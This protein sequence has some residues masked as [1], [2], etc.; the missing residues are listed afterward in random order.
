MICFIKRRKALA[1]A[2]LAP[3]TG[4]F[5]LLYCAMLLTRFSV[6]HDC[7]IYHFLLDDAIAS[8]AATYR[9]RQRISDNLCQRHF[10]SLLRTLIWGCIRHLPPLINSL[11]AGLP[12]HW[13]RFDI[14]L[15]PFISLP[16][17]PPT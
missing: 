6:A 13:P 15:M 12:R 16:H 8:H 1:S 7:L 5:R 2:F 9:Y 3:F 10:A 17:I 11:M 14:S 4:D